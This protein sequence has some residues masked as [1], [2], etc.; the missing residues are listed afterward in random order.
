MVMVFYRWQAD[1]GGCREGSGRGRVS[2]FAKGNHRVQRRWLC[3]DNRAEVVDEGPIV[4]MAEMVMDDGD[5]RDE[6]VSKCVS[7]WV[8]VVSKRIAEMEDKEGTVRGCMVVVVVVFE[9]DG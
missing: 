4:A 9:K 5:E 8:S 7:G 1:Y 2:L 3:D 6:R